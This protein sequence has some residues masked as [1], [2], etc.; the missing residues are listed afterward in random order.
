M[1]RGSGLGSEEMAWMANMWLFFSLFSMSFLTEI[2]DYCFSADFG[3]MLNVTMFTMSPA[4]PI[5]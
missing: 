3:F 4:T 1:T 2:I 5:T